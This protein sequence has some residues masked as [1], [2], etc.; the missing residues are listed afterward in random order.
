LQENAAF[1]LTQSP[2]NVAADNEGRYNT[3]KPHQENLVGL[4]Y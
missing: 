1:L 2:A 4:F 3:K